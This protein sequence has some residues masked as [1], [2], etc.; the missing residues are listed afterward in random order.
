MDYTVIVQVRAQFGDK[1][2][3]IGVFHGEESE[4]VFDCPNVDATQTAV[5]FLQGHQVGQEQTLEIN[6][7]GLSGGLPA[8]PI[9]AGLTES[10]GS[11]H[12]HGF[13]GKSFG[14]S[15]YV[16]LVSPN[17]LRSSNN[18]MRVAS[19][20]RTEFVIDNVVVFYKT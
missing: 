6:G 9:A 11:N 18:V 10:I 4:W 17:V 13:S 2:L 8:G 15:A 1:D 20:E 14:W 12:V 5:L 7:S 16:M 3:D 19:R